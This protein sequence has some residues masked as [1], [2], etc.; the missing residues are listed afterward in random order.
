MK[1]IC[2]YTDNRL[3]DPIYSTVQKHLK[4]SGLPIVS[5]SLEPIDFGDNEVI[6]GKR[7]Y[8]TMVKQII[9]CLRRSKSKY[10]FF[11]EHD[12]LYPKSYFEFTPPRDDIFYYNDN[13]WRWW[14]GS[15]TA[16][17]HE[18]MLSLSC[19]SCNRELALKHYTNRIK[20]ILDFGWDKVD[21]G[22][23]R[24][25]RRMGYEPGTKKRRRGGLTDDSFETWHSKEPV[26][27]IRHKKTFSRPKVR[28]EDFKHKPKW[29][30]EIPVEDIDGW[31]LKN[32][33]NL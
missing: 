13:A 11:C 29:W 7:S 6:L 18:R 14:F 26:I 28:I 2:Y 8:T 3:D 31:D 1:S 19:M 23:P 20:A 27:D 12:C 4:E 9:S 5:S 33:F 17:R 16:I 25:A 21:F 10:V 30:E 22:E 32:M 24:W 15:D